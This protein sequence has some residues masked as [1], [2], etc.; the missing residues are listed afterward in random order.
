MYTCRAILA[1]L[2]ATIV[3]ARG[4]ESLDAQLETIRSSRHMPGLSAMAVKNGRIVA[5]GAAGLRREG[6][7]ARLLVTDPINIASC[8]KWMTA[9][10]AGRLVDRGV[11]AWSTRV[12]DL[13]PE[14]AKF[15]AAFAEATLDQ[16]L[17]HRAGIQQ[18][19]TFEK[20]HWPQLLA[21]K[22]TIPQIRRWVSETV[23]EDAPE[24]APGTFLYANQGYTVA[25]TMLEIASGRDWETL[26]REEIFTPLGMKSAT[27]G[28]VYDAAL[29]PKAPVGHELPAGETTPVPRAPMKPAVHL[30]YQASNGPG[31]YVACT[32]QDWAKFLQAQVKNDHYLSAATAQRLQEPFSGNDGYSRGI[33]VADRAWAKPGRAL[34]HSGDIFGEDTVVWMA[35][36]KQFIVVVFTNCR[37][38][39]KST[40]LALDDAA[41]YLVSHFADAPADGPALVP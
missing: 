6:E 41:G 17:A 38:A 14:Y 5:Q 12:R 3:V 16:L 40:M 10:V 2:L 28:I 31:G 37:S 30:R 23:L 19:S 39:D 21:Q 15:N 36:A 20:N 27:L 34:T 8:T 13:F 25:A 26:M 1:F 22:G 33:G 18:G 29:P 4:Q 7:A 35:P 32:L 9:T 24:V 11:I